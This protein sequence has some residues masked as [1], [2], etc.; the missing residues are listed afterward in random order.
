MGLTILLVSACGISTSPNPS[1]PSSQTSTTQCQAIEHDV[2]TTQVCGQPQRIAVLGPHMLD[3]LLSLGI[4]PSGY[5]E[6]NLYFNPE[7]IG[8]PITHIPYLDNLITSSPINLGL[9]D[10]PSLEALLKFK[11]DL[12][13]GER[14]FAQQYYSKLSQIAPTLLFEGSSGKDDWKTSVQVIAKALGHQSDAHKVISS[15]NQKLA[16]VRAQ[17]TPVAVTQPRVLLL[18]ARDL[19]NTFWAYDN[20]TFAGGL[21]EEIGFQ[22]VFPTDQ[23]Q[24]RKEDRI[25]LEVLPQVKADII[26]A[27]ASDNEMENSKHVWNQSPITQSLQA[28]QENRV[29]FV[30]YHIWGSNVRGPITAE[31]LIDEAHRLLSPLAESN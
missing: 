6:I 18:D 19:P 11:P 14:V 12:I 7:T 23:N 20:E 26:I 24:R 25:S 16:T 8:E 29:Y 28:T 13:L 1:S 2:G 15:H 22:L 10:S 4:Q 31:I 17:L 5:A 27:I 3:I 21:I 9:R 30:D